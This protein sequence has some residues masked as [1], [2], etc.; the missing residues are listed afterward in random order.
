MEKLK[1]GSIAYLIIFALSFVTISSS[2]EQ[3]ATLSQSELASLVEDSF[4]VGK[5]NSG[6][7]IQVVAYAVACAESSKMPCVIGDSGNS[8]GLWQI[9]V[10]SHP[11]YDKNRLTE[12]SYNAQAAAKI[13]SGGRN[14]EAWSAWK[15]GEYT[16]YIPEAESALGVTLNQS[17][18]TLY[19][20]EGSV[21]GPVIS[22]A[23][24]TGFDADGNS[25]Q[26]ITDSEGYVTLTGNPGIWSFTAS[27][28]GYSDNS[29]DQ[30]IPDDCV[31]HAFLLISR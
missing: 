22:G 18:L 16:I 12:P 30:Y 4:P 28:Y 8:I 10:P 24:V 19:I 11:E 5:T 9:Y 17:T 29:W 26:G 25:F 7:N 6:E 21:S 1:V 2:S 31:R 27:A 23:Q 3:C 14:W 20:H 15:N 13:S